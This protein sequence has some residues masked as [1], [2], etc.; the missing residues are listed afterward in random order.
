MSK[1]AVAQKRKRRGRSGKR[2]KR[3]P[4]RETR[5]NPDDAN[6]NANANNGAKDSSKAHSGGFVVFRVRQGPSTRCVQS[7]C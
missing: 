5:A 2:L 7:P 6:A 4:K 3:P 1:L